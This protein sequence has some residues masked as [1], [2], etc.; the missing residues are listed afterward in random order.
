MQAGRHHTSSTIPRVRPHVSRWTEAQSKER[1]GLALLAL[2]V[3]KGA[4]GSSGRQGSEN[5]KACPERMRSLP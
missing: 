5:V 3:A 4:H 1:K 2:R